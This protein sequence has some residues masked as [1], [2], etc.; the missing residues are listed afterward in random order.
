MTEDK[1]NPV[2]DDVSNETDEQVSDSGSDNNQH[3]SDS[4]PKRT[5]GRI[6]R[7]FWYLVLVIIIATIAWV[8]VEKPYQQLNLDFS[9]SQAD[10]KADTTNNEPPV[11][12]AEQEVEK[13]SQQLETIERQLT[14]IKRTSDSSSDAKEQD[15]RRLEQQLSQVKSNIQQQNEQLTKLSRQLPEQQFEQISQWRLFEAKQTVSAAARLLWAAEDYPAALQLLKLADKQLA[16]IESATAIQI[17]QQLAEDIARV[18]ALADNQADKLV[19]SIAGLQ[20]RLNDLPDRVD[21]KQLSPRK[22]TDQNLSTDANDWRTNLAKNWDD[23]LNTFIRIQPATNDPEPLLTSSQREAMTLRMNLLL[24]MAQHAALTRNDKLWRTNIDQALTL[25]AELKGDS[26]AAQ[27]I[28]S[29]LTELRDAPMNQRRLEQLQALDALAKATAQG[30][31][32]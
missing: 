8:V 4:K 13:L 22:S 29:R 19:L 28:S 24:T 14:A 18:E 15:V 26:K 23:F 5:V 3:S 25:I 31:L 32:Q 30:G 12:N 27:D 6:K 11:F 1:Q 7:I 9:S 21:E 16:G 17:R 10:T 20:Q 2:E